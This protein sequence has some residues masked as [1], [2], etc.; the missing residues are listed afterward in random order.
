MAPYAI[1][2]SVSGVFLPHEKAIAIHRRRELDA[3]ARRTLIISRSG[4]V[5]SETTNSGSNS[6]AIITSG[7]RN[8]ESAG[9]NKSQMASNV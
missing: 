9:S 1:Q 8:S 3:V 7:S 4:A 5:L 2:S 6:M